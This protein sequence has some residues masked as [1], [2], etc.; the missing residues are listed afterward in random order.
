MPAA[1]KD[2]GNISGPKYEKILRQSLSVLL[3]NGSL[4][5]SSFIFL[6]ARTICIPYLENPSKTTAA[7]TIFRRGL[8][9]WFPTAVAL[10]V[11]KILSSTIGTGYIDQY[12][13]ET[14]NLSLEVPYEIPNTLAYFNS[15]FN[16]FW[17]NK[18][19]FEQAGNTAFP[20]QTLWII[21]VIYSQSYTVYLSMIIIPYTRSSWRVKAYLCFILSAWWVQS[22]AWYSISG[23]LLTDVVINMQYMEKAKMGL[24]IWRSMRLPTWIAFICLM[25]AGLVLQ[26]LWTD[27][28]PQYENKELLAHAGL[29]YTGGLNT[30]IN[31]KEPQARDDS[32]L[33]IVGFH[34]LLESST[35]AQRIFDNPLFVYLGKR[36]LSKFLDENDFATD[37]FQSLPKSHITDALLSRLVPRPKSHYLYRWHQAPHVSVEA[38]KSRGGGRKGDLLHC[39]RGDS[40]SK[41]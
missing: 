14:G 15:V 7:G 18:Q 28:R 37:S 5:Y 11:V 40:S 19:I 6:S 17:T 20:S 35:F 23:L 27:W 2:S 30:R 29:Y 39:L 13:Q 31:A 8:R 22:W 25:G 9:L 16:L 41:R 32:Y 24:K 12:K 3:W 1:V 36:S 10:A 26:Y 33:L 34:L 38:F 21:N 4:I